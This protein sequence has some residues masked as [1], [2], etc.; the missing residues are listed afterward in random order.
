[1]ATMKAVQLARAKGDFELVEREI[2]EPGPGQVRIKVDACG[3]C[4][5]DSFVKDGTFPG[6]AYPRI[7][8]HEVIGRVDR[9]GAG[10]TSFWEGEQ[11]GV[12]WH[13]GHDFTCDRC[14]AGDFVTC[15]NERIT[16]ISFDGGYAQYM[17]APF[18]AIARVPVGLEPAKAA[19]LLCAGITTYNSLR[20]S[21]A[22]P[23]DLVAVQ[24]IGGLGHL[25]VQ[26]A[27]QMGFRTVA[28]GRGRD[29]EALARQLGATHYIDTS[30]TDPAKELMQLGGA[31]VIL[32]TAPNSRAISALINGLGVDGK[33]LVVA[34]DVA[35]L[36]VSPI[37]LI[38]QRRSIQGWPSG[39]AR[40][41]E[42]T[43]GFAAFTGAM[44]MVQTYPLEQAQRAYQDMLSS[45]VRFRAVLVM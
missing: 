9:L 20:N 41:S 11:V 42:E 23:G 43:L 18:E 27:R 2:P 8:G 1:M 21:G 15:R 32:A 28:I 19:P 45:K 37:Q 34:A 6:I 7:P 10:V 30:A 44:P 24:G 22:R 14:R 38:G 40:D 35:A 25:G 26:F 5:S 3:V 4:H 36:E 12:G 33:L 31:R 39:D 29:K 13:G 17:V 16:G